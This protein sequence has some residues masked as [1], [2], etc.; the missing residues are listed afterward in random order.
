MEVKSFD[1]SSLPTDKEPL[2]TDEQ[3]IFT[4]IF[5][6]ELQNYKASENSSNTK[7]KLFKNL[8]ISSIIAGIAIIHAVTPLSDLLKNLM[9]SNIIIAI[10]ICLLYIFLSYM[11]VKNV[12]C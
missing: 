5:Q 7:Q 12:I 1:L 2:Q 8:L 6:P 4:T 9:R 10:V 3:H 11:L